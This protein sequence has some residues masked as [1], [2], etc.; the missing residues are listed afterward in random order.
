MFITGCPTT[1]A[2]GLCF[3]AENEGV[4]CGP[5]TPGHVERGVRTGENR[6]K[7][8]FIEEAKTRVIF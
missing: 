6:L 3:V 4:R 7:P 1:R 8:F 5:T 2:Q